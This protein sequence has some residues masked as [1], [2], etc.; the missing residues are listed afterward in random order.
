MTAIV[1]PAS[2]TWLALALAVERGLFT[3]RGECSAV[4]RVHAAVLAALRNR[5]R[6]L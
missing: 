5:I 2:M 3:V 6:V 1:E 4:M